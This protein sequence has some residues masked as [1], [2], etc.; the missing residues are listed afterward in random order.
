MYYV[1]VSGLIPPSPSFLGHIIHLAGA[2]IDFDERNLALYSLGK[3]MF[4]IHV[5]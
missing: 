5:G 1:C 3:E 2:L 4:M